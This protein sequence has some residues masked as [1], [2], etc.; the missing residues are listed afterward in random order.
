MPS[1]GAD[2]EAGTLVEWLVRP[3]DRVTR[4]DIVA[5]VETQKGAIEIEIFEDGIVHSLDVELG[6]RLPVGAQL[7]TILSD[8]EAPPSAPAAPIPDTPSCAAVAPEMSAPPPRPD[9]TAP[10]PTG[11]GIAASP[12]A[13]HRAAE[14]GLDLAGVTGRGPDGAILLA[15]VEAA[16]TGGTTKGTPRP[17][18]TSDAMAQMR[19]AIAA[20]MQRSKREIP[21]FQ[22]AQ[23]I[24][25]HT[26]SDWLAARNADVP[27][28]ERIL[29]G[30]L[31]M[32]AAAVAAANVKEMNGHY[33]ADGFRPAPGVNLG[34][35]VALRGGGL[36]A[37]AIP[38]ADRLP[39]PALM[40]AMKDLV[41]RARAMRLRSSELTTGTLTVSSLGET[42]ADA[43]SGII[44]PPQVALLGIGAPKLRPW[45]LD[46][47]VVPRRLATFT[48]SADHRVSDG[49]QANRFLAEIETALQHP[50]AL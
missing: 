34:V 33:E 42:G 3:G 27:P 40:A 20:A 11:F 49:R 14:C 46:G 22:L 38:D 43:M 31:F 10:V 26:A 17:A 47:T 50:E 1:L 15:D 19:K 37:P 16:A 12:A 9:T 39:L 44:F 2:M 23:T 48:L 7:A 24:D 25:I 28:G 18:A 8:G 32:K 21:H 36:V 13:R 6:A 29:L 35:A 4:G 41:S 5:V 30:T 45:V